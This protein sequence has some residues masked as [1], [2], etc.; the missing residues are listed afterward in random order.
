[1]QTIRERQDEFFCPERALYDLE[2]HGPRLNASYEPIE[3]SYQLRMLRWSRTQQY[4]AIEASK[5]DGTMME[6][7]MNLRFSDSE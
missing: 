3:P 7:G 2:I 1:M 5:H 6:T 4:R